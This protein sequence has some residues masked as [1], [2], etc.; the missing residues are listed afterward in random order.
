MKNITPKYEKY[1]QDILNVHTDK[2]WY[3][4]NGTTKKNYLLK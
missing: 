1:F 4:T 3:K 2:G